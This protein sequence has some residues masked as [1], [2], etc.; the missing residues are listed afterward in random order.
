MCVGA[1]N[2]AALQPA[3]IL[4]ATYP[5]EAKF[6]RIEGIVEAKCSI[7]QVG[8]VAAVVIVSGHPV[9]ASSVKANLLQWTFHR[10]ENASQREEEVRVVYS[11]QLNGRCDSHKGCKEQFWFE[12][13]GQVAVISELPRINTGK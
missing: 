6:G 10:T 4:G 5:Q 7:R 3:R 1:A 11:F 9:L 13:P 8:T 2:P 12:Y